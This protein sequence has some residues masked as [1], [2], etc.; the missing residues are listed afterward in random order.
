MRGN[1]GGTLPLVVAGDG[2]GGGNT[3]FRRL[4]CRLL[5]VLVIICRSLLSSTRILRSVIR[6]FLT[7]SLTTNSFS[8]LLRCRFRVLNSSITTRSRFRQLRC[9]KRKDLNARGYLMITN[10]HGS[11]IILNGLQG[12]D[13]FCR[14]LLRK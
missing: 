13:N 12:V 5:S 6:H 11:S 8:R 7:T 9:S 10:A 2:T 1:T 14:Y 4:G 3:R